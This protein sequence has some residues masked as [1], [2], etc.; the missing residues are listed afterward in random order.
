MY[1]QAVGLQRAELSV[2]WSVKIL[3]LVT[4][5]LTGFPVVLVAAELKIIFDGSFETAWNT[6]I[7][8]NYDSSFEI[9]IKGTIEN[10]EH[11]TSD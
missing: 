3:L 11:E 1:F 7:E 8:I 10:P 9:I 5:S 4:N 6:G 2:N